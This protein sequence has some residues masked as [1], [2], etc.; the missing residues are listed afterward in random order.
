MEL[1]QTDMKSVYPFGPKVV[2]W[3]QARQMRDQ[4]FQK[5]VEKNGNV[6]L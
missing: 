4:A 6:S 3:N 1:A 5:N 2:G